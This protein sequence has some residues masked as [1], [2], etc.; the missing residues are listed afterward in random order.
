MDYTWAKRLDLARK[1]ANFISSISDDLGDE[2][3]YLGMPIS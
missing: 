1:P 2:L 3:Q